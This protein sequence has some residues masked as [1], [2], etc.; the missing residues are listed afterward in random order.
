MQHPGFLCMNSQPIPGDFFDDCQ[1]DLSKTLAEGKP[2]IT[3][4]IRLWKNISV[5]ALAPVN[6]NRQ[7][8]I[9]LIFCVILAES[10]RFSNL[11]A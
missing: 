7:K 1:A 6:F 5:S 9:M 8:K 4:Y 2:T 10:I 3:T 11:C